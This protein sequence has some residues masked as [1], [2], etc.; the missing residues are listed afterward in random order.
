[1]KKKIKV[2]FV[3][4]MTLLIVFTLIPT[5]LAC[6]RM[7]E[8]LDTPRETYTVTVTRGG[9]IGILGE[10]EESFSSVYTKE[11]TPGDIVHI[12]VFPYEDHF[13]GPFAYFRIQT[14]PTIDFFS[15]TIDFFWYRGFKA[16][17]MP[18]SDV[19]IDIGHGSTVSIENGIFGIF[20]RSVYYG[21][22]A[23]EIEADEPEEGYRFVRW[24]IVSGDAS[25]K[26]VDPTSPNTLLIGDWRVSGAVRAVFAPITELD[27]G[28]LWLR[29]SWYF[30]QDGV[31]QTGWVH[32]NNQWYF[33]NPHVSET[34]HLWSQS[35]GSMRTG[36]VLERGNWYFLNPQRGTD[37]HRAG[38]PHGS[39]Q[40]GWVWQGNNWY[41]LNPSRGTEG[42]TSNLPHG[43]MRTGWVWQNGW[44]FLNPPR[45]T[46]GH[47]VG[48]P[49]GA[50]RTGWAWQGSSWFYLNPVSG[51][52][53]H[54][55]NF[56]G[57]QMFTGSQTIGGERFTL[58]NSGRCVVGRGC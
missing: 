58:N 53:G 40:T 5:M 27:N 10:D 55:R 30:Y 46:D 2:L 19:E 8:P 32:V 23:I 50:M 35:V 4:V 52:V 18:S 25:L 33:L 17:E 29:N 45:G 42:N 12:L 28:W 22:L 21:K 13:R 11:F 14:S 20:G 51:T 48:H 15:P 44:F 37:G 57:G 36:W 34:A 3:L 39:M 47:R 41:F 54:N 26:F 1:M 38:R 6:A 56:R 49:H 9:A 7:I 16:F 24:E 31:R 43:A